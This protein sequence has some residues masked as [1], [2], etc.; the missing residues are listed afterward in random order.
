MTL[1]RSGDMTSF[2]PLS[3]PPD[4]HADRAEDFRLFR[5]RS[6]LFASFSRVR[7]SGQI[8]I[9]VAPVDLEQLELGPP[10]TPRLDCAIAI[11]EKNWCF[12]EHREQL[13]CVYSF[14]PFHLLRL[15]NRNTFQFQTVMAAPVSL[16]GTS[17][18]LFVS[19]QVS[20]STSPVEFRGDLILFLHERDNEQNYQHYAVW[21]DSATLRPC[22][23]SR[24]P[25]FSGGDAQGLRPSVL[26]LMS[27]LQSAGDYWFF[28]GEGD[29]YLSF[30]TLSESRLSEL[31]AD[32]I[33]IGLAEAADLKIVGESF[34]EH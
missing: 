34:N 10:L 31:L 23:M 19:R 20:L 8:E 6:E 21:L 24:H 4:V 14:Q 11:V 15:A 33:E 25:I 12:F 9:Q 29:E 28:F 13:F 22:R 26:Y 27:V 7:M 3:V 18:S 30:L 5:W 17:H 2:S 32:S 16:L 1:N